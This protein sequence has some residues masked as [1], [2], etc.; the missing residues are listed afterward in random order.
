MNMIL[1]YRLPTVTEYREQGWDDRAEDFHAFMV[2]IDRW[3]SRKCGM[4]LMD[5]PDYDYASAFEDGND[6][7]A[8][9]LEVLM[10]AGWEG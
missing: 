8:I 10:E 6:P 1:S 3:I 5:L 9:A 2:L 7:R 4:S